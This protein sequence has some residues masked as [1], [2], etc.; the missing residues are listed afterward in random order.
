LLVMSMVRFELVD[1]NTLPEE[2]H[3]WTAGNELGSV[4]LIWYSPICPGVKP[5]KAGLKAAE[6]ISAL[7]YGNRGPALGLKSNCTAT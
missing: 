2:P 5:T 1:Q 4:T 7:T 6:T 3:G